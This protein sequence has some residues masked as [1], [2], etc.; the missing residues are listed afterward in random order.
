M[1]CKC[2]SAVEIKF[3]K[4]N[5][6]AVIPSKKD[7]DAG[8]DIYAYID[9]DVFV[10]EPF[11]TRMVPTGIASAIP[12]EYYFQV[13]E[14]G[15]TGTKGMKKSAGVIDSGFRGEWFI[16][17]TNC[18]HKPIVITKDETFTNNN[19]IVYPYGKAIAQAVLL[20]VPKT[21]I[22]EIS[23]EELEKIPSQRG[24]GI[25]GSSNK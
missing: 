4:V 16:P 2:N 11:T 12:E 3:A 21:K 8:Y 10:I 23:Y 18:N 20:P 22:V 17:I 25:M 9:E 19:Y 14:R 13:E 5:K 15:S 7:E 6:E 1:S 24:K